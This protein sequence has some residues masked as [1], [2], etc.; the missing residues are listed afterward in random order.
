MPQG[1]LLGPALF[2]I[3]INNLLAKL[4]EN[5]TIAY[6]DDVTLVASGK[7]GD[8]ALVSLQELINIMHNCAT[9]NHLCLDAAK[10]FFMII[11]HS[12]R[13]AATSYPPLPIRI[14]S[15]NIIFVQLL[16]ILSVILS[17]TLSWNEHAQN[18]C[19][20]VAKKTRRTTTN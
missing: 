10:C 8:S 5:F 18:V 3:Y 7:S 13:K 1:S 11:P 2:L 19:S 4:S 15:S 9:D 6:A 16:K 20:K 17:S 12:V 14:G